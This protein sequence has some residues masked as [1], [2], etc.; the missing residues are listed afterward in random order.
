MKRL[1][2]AFL[3]AVLTAL[4]CVTAFAADVKLVFESSYNADTNSVIVEV[5]VE[6]P[7]DMVSA[8]LRLGFDHS[9]FEYVASGDNSTISDMMVISGLSVANTGLACVSAIFTEKCEDSYLTDGRLRLTTFT[10]TPLTEDFDIN[11][12]CLWAYSYDIGDTDISKSIAAVGNAA[13]KNG[14]TEAISVAGSDNG[15]ASASDKLNGKWYVYVIAVVA[16]VAIVAG[17]AV[18]AIKSGEKDE[19]AEKT[20]DENKD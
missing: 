11:D 4:M 15:S 13:L 6:N 12:F 2:S 8:D 5:Y 14:K 18:F 7:G 16:G 10:F 20:A 3:A 9:V 19:K 1:I 17:V